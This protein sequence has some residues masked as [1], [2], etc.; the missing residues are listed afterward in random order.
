MFRLCAAVLQPI[1]DKRIVK[2]ISEIADSVSA[3]FG[4]VATVT[5]MFVILLTIII[6]IGKPL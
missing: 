4:L 5:V 2:C 3:V 1:S 6:N